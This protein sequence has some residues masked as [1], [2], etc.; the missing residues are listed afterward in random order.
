M[1][2]TSGPVLH[3]PVATMLNGAVSAKGGQSSPVIKMES[4]LGDGVGRFQRQQN[5][6]KRDR[7]L[8]LKHNTRAWTFSNKK[9]KKKALNTQTC[10]YMNKAA[11]RTRNVP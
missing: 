9:T 10:P 5:N 1:A 3:E 8:T 7:E 11:E 6:L 4:G 2:H